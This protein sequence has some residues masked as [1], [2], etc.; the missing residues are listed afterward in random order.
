[1]L[2]QV[3]IKKNKA[4][5]VTC[6]L[7]HGSPLPWPFMS[8]IRKYSTCNISISAP[9]KLYLPKRAVGWIWPRAVV[10]QPHSRQCLT[11]ATSPTLPFIPDSSQSCTLDLYFRDILLHKGIWIRGCFGSMP[12]PSN[13]NDH[14]RHG[15]QELSGGPS[16][17]HL[18]WW[19]LLAVLLPHLPH[20]MAWLVRLVWT[21]PKSVTSHLFNIPF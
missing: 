17:L 5:L 20:L 1:M 15:Q 21:G 12:Q 2:A 6:V 8:C 3:S 16:C 9:M 11:S 7:L 13:L 19:M 14:F 18:S 4:V 10:C